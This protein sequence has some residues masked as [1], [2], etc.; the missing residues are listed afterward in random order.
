MICVDACDAL[1][2]EIQPHAQERGDLVGSSGDSV[3]TRVADGQPHNASYLSHVSYG[4]GA[5]SP[6]DSS[7]V[8]EHVETLT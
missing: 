8:T 1:S 7:Y 6:T 5:S 4:R 3:R 2:R